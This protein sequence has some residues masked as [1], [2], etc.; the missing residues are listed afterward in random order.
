MKT[1]ETISALLRFPR[2]NCSPIVGSTV[3]HFPADLISGGHVARGCDDRYG[4]GTRSGSLHPAFR[5]RDGHRENLPSVLAE[6][7]SKFQLRAGGARIGRALMSLIPI[8]PII[9]SIEIHGRW[10][11]SSRC[12]PIS[13]GYRSARGGKRMRFYPFPAFFRPSRTRSAEATRN[14]PTNPKANTVIRISSR[15]AGPL[16]SSARAPREVLYD[17]AERH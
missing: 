5:C 12:W 4:S 8:V 9:P 10:P 6:G 7:P 17:G 11:P 1:L 16:A 3:L 13:L 14:A 15:S 2:S